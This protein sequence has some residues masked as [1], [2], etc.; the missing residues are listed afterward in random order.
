MHSRQIL[1]RLV[2][3]KSLLFG[4]AVATVTA[5]VSVFAPSGARADLV[6]NGGFETGDFT[7]W[8]LA[9]NTGFT[10]VDACC[11]HTGNFGAFFGAFGSDTL[12][13]Q[14]LATTAGGNYNLTFWLQSDGNQPNDWSV[15]FDGTTLMSATNAPAFP[16]TQFTFSVT[17]ASALTSLQFTFRN[18][19]GF[20]LLD[21]VGVGA[22]PLPAALP[23]F[24][25]GLGALGLLGW[26]RKRK[27]VA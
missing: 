16:Y 3:S 4:I 2:P 26:R 13:S 19:F 7:G 24:A 9:G 8:T 10:G 18:D 25:T 20:F 17:A 23:L 5:V 15:S 12:L 27:T 14:N 11:A 6:A 22:V 21:D 1:T